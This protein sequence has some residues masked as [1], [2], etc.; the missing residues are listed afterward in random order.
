[1]SN[2]SRCWTKARAWNMFS[3]CC[4]TSGPGLWTRREAYAND[5]AFP[6]TLTAVTAKS[7]RSKADKDLA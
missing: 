2:V 7:N 4:G 5:Q 3:G 6:L 1:M